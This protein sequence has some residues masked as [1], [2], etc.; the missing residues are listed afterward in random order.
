MILLDHIVEF[1]KYCDKCKYHDLP[2]EKEPCREC[3]LTSVREG[4]R[5]PEYFVETKTASIMKG[6][7]KPKLLYL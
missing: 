6:G 7:D 5:R 4:S 3:L 2:E 1:D